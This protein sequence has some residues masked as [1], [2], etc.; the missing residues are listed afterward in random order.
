MCNL[1]A[2]ASASEWLLYIS[3][4]EARGLQLANIRVTTKV[5]RCYTLTHLPHLTHLTHLTRLTVRRGLL[6]VCVHC[7]LS[8]EPELREVGTALL[9]N[10]AAKEVKTVVCILSL[11]RS[12]FHSH[13][14]HYDRKNQSFSAFLI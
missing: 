2:H 8:E 6:Q 9:Y 11:S 10:V 5:R 4:W 1:F 7:A 14:T 12:L 3:E 13:Y